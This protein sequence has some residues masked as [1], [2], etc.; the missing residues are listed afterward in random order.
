MQGS[1][2]NKSAKTI[3][4]A[5]QLLESTTAK[6]YDIQGRLV[7][8][9]LLDTTRLQTIDVSYLNA[10]IYIV[11]LENGLQHKTQKVIIY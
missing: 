9:T 8:T 6:L 4:I 7:E 11:Q 2:S 5:G 3:V 1:Y 10:G